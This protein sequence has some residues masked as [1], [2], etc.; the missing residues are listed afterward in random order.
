M[1]ETRVSDLSPDAHR[2]FPIVIATMPISALQR[3]VALAVI[4]FLIVGSLSVA[5]FASTPLPRV[6]VFVPVVQTVMCVV[7]VITAALLFAQYSIVPKP[8]VLVLAGGYVF[9]G[10]FA[11]LQ[12]LAFPGAYSA[13]GLIGDGT[14]SPAW[15]F[16][17][18]HSSFLLAV[19]VYALSKD[20]DIEPS[21]SRQSR[22]MRIAIA[23][24]FTL[25]ITGGTTWL[26]TAGAKH[27]PTT[28]LSTTLQTG[29]AR[30]L[31]V[32]LWLLSFVAFTLL[33]VRRRTVLDLWL[34]VILVAWWPNFLVGM[35]LAV[36][37][38]SFGWY[39][40]R[41]FALLATSTLL[42]V[43]LAQSTLLYARLANAILLL[44]RE[45]ADKLMSLEAATTAIAHEIG[46]PLAAISSRG[47]AALNWLRKSP[48]NVKEASASVTVMV[49]ASHRA[50]EIISSIRTLFKRGSDRKL[51]VQ[52]EDIARQAL[53]L[54]QHDLQSNE[55]SVLTEFQADLPAVQADRTQLQQIIL[56]LIKNAIEA[57][58]SK[59][60]ASRRLRLATRAKGNS[61]VLLSVED[62]GAGISAES[63]TEI[64]DPF[65][66]TKSDGMGLGL[67]I[68]RTIAE[69]HGGSLRL[70]ESS[71]RGSVF[72][73][74]LPAEPTHAGS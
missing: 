37:R 16:V 4:I 50:D 43:L 44:R 51:S 69:S 14:N 23:I 34:L 22:W 52:V 68:C 56:N 1:P 35:S 32:F 31:N 72:E 29:F 57:M 3:K 6:D 65:F 64:F 38:F 55:V 19:I 24:T 20:A 2:D 73:V 61:T 48:P 41:F 47:G 49:E 27:L 5:P 40:A 18:W 67:A 54:V 59:P 58:N 26:A 62:S 71:S 46:Q 17:L 12:T 7:D 9:S 28:Y 66:T 60:P 21:L 8:A 33:L 13:N 74:A 15:L 10:L 42:F 36:V 53:S 63:Q 25:A 11:F 45:R 70:T 30:G 39:I